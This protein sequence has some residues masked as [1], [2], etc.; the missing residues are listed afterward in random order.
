MPHTTMHGATPGLRTSGAEETLP[1]DSQVTDLSEKSFL[2][3]AAQYAMAGHQLIRSG[4]GGL[5]AARWGMV[6]H[7]A[8]LGEAMR[9]LAQVSGVSQ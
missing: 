4:D 9:F 8:D 1:T 3:L 2:T 5:Y 6:R 7:L